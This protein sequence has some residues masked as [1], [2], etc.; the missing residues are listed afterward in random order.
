MPRRICS[1]LDSHSSFDCAVAYRA[2][3]AS[4]STGPGGVEGEP[5]PAADEGGKRAVAAEGVRDQHR[6]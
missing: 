1:E 3:D 2:A 5:C 6:E 4:A